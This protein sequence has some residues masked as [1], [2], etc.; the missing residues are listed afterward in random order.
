GIVA[1]GGMA[2]PEDLVTTTGMVSPTEEVVV[3]HLIQG[4]Y[5]RIGGDVAAH[6]DVITL[7]TVNHHRS[8]PPQQTPVATLH[9]LVT[10]ELRLL[11]QRNGVHIVSGGHHRHADR[12]RPSTL[13][14]GADHVL[15]TLSAV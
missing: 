15:R 5:P 4:G 12:L 14:Q 13:Q 10:R 11:I 7:S 2:L 6:P 1:R 9:L 8:V 3:P